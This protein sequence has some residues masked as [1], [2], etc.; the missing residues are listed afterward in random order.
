VDWKLIEPDSVQDPVFFAPLKPAEV[1]E[2]RRLL[3]L[4]PT[5]SLPAFL[6]IG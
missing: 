5:A 2:L 6:D 1:E 3:G 4:P